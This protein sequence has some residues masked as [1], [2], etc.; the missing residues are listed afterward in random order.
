MDTAIWNVLFVNTH[1]NKH[2]RKSSQHFTCRAYVLRLHSLDG[3]F[4]AQGYPSHALPSSPSSSYP[5]CAQ[6]FDLNCGVEA[7][8]LTPFPSLPS[9]PSYSYSYPSCA[10][11]FDLG[12]GLEPSK[13]P[14]GTSDGNQYLRIKLYDEP[15]KKGVAPKGG[16]TPKAI[17]KGVT[18]PDSRMYWLQLPNGASDYSTESCDLSTAPGERG[19]G[20]DARGRA[21]GQD[22]EGGVMGGRAMGMGLGCWFRGA[23]FRGKID[24]AFGCLLRALPPACGA[25]GQPPWAN[26]L[27]ASGALRVI[28]TLS[29]QPHLCTFPPLWGRGVRVFYFFWGGDRR[30][31]TGV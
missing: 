17:G 20:Q 31:G 22:S 26:H 21:W 29:P 6:S 5:S 2:Y 4:H 19:E 14:N 3:N 1:V 13:C 11:F 23:N 25:I 12:Y 7:P 16:V 9:S 10:Q 24:I 30:M 28:P 18:G 27:L 15:F 8:S